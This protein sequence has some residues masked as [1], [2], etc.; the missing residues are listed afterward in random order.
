[1][2]N[3]RKYILQISYR[4]K[5]EFIYYYYL[6]VHESSYKSSSIDHSSLFDTPN[7][8][9]QEKNILYFYKNILYM[10]IYS[11]ISYLKDN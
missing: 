4:H 2:R 7:F 10:Y 8:V 6:Y 1:M 3:L 5:H 11:E 9:R